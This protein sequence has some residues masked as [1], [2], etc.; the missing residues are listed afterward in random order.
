MDVDSV[1]DNDVVAGRNAD[2]YNDLDICWWL[3]W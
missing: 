1:Q 2:G 3:Q